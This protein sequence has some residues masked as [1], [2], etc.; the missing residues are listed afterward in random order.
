MSLESHLPFITL[1]DSDQVV[2]MSEVNFQIDF[3]FAWAVEE[4]GDVR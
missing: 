2:R 4:V 3:G 1:S